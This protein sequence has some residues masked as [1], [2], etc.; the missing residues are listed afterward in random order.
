[1]R[2]KLVALGGDRARYFLG[3]DDGDGGQ[4]DQSG[5]SDYL[6]QHG[7]SIPFPK[8]LQKTSQLRW[9]STRPEGDMGRTI[10]AGRGGS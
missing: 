4:T 3:Y 2:W 9:V 7:V 6:Q 10:Y 5:H 1:M 8:E